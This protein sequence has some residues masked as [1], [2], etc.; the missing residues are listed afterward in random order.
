[1]KRWSYIILTVVYFTV[2][3]GCS[4]PS[5]YP[6]PVADGSIIFLRTKL[7]S[8]DGYQY[9]YLKVLN[10]TMNPERL[11]AEWA[12]WYG[13]KQKM[14]DKVIAK[15]VGSYTPTQSID[16]KWASLYWTGNK[17][18]YGW[19]QTTPIVDG[20]VHE[21]ATYICVVRPHTNSSLSELLNECE[22]K[23]RW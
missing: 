12:Y 21:H 6:E 20:E 3:T 1:M 22:F 2:L 5:N 15:G 11:D 4:N 7:L 9:G 18:G 16:I 10:Q 13:S 14:M 17:P 19:F 23:A 8:G